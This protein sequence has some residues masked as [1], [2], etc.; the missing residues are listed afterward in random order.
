LIA[1]RAFAHGH[2]GAWKAP[3]DAALEYRTDSIIPAADD[4]TLLPCAPPNI[5]QRKVTFAFGVRRVSDIE[6]M[7]AVSRDASESFRPKVFA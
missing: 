6:A 5:S 3:G 7:R 4:D 2:P 1:W